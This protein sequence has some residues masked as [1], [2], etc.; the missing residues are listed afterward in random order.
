MSRIDVRTVYKIRRKSDG[1]FSMGGSWPRFNKNGK[2]WKQ[3]GHLTSHLNIVFDNF[4]NQRHHR[5]H[6][7]DCEIVAY[8]LIETP[9]G[10]PMSIEE[11]MNI[12]AQKK[13]EKEEA[14]RK[15][16]TDEEL[17]VRYEQYKKLKKEFE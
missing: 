10:P 4:R 13:A 2:I 8:E 7:D 14:A 6:Y 17:R 9:V 12:L 15:R 16:K 5:D 3:K 11:Y 1:L